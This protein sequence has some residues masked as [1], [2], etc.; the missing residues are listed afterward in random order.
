V[1]QIVSFGEWMETRRKRL[2]LTRKAL[3]VLAGCSTVTVQKI[4]RDERRPSVQLAQLLAQ[5][6]QIPENEQDDFIRRA[7]GE[8]VPD[9]PPPMTMTVTEDTGARFV[10]GELLAEGAHGQVYRG[11]DLV[12]GQPVVIKR[13]KP[14]LQ[15]QPEVVARFLR[16]SEALR[17]LNHPNI[18]KMLAAFAA[19]G[20]HTIVMEFVPGGSLR[21]LLDQNGKLSEAL[22]VDIAL[23]LADALSRAHHLDIL[24]RDLKPDNVLLAADG[25]PRLTDFGVARLVQEPAQLTTTGV[26]IGSPAYLSPEALRCEAVDSRADIWSFGV[27]LYEMLAGRRPFAGEQV[28]MIL[29]QILHDAPPPIEQ[30][31]PD[32]SP[33]LAVLIAQM[34]QKTA[35][36]RPSSMR[37]VAAAL[38][39]IGQG[40]GNGS[41]AVLIPSAPPI[42]TTPAITVSHN[43]PGQPTP[44]LGR[45]TELT[46]L[47]DLLTQP[48]SRLVTIVGPGGMGK[49]R[50]AMTLAESLLTTG[51]FTN[52]IFFVPLAPLNDPE[53]MVLALVEAL[54]FPL[55]SE[56]Q[57]RRTTQEQVLDYLCEKRLLLILDNFEHL[58]GDLALV[59]DI[60]QKTANVQIV[61]TSRERLQL[62]EEQVYPIEGLAFPEEGVEEVAGYTAVQLFLQTAQRI[63]PDFALQADDLPHLIRICQLVGG[64]PLGVELAAGWVDMLPLSEI[65]N[66]IQRSSDFLETELRNVPERHRSI[67][68]VFEASWQRLTA[69]EQ[70]VFPQLSVFRGGFTRRAGQAV[71]GASLRL[72]GRLGNKSLLQY[73]RQRDRYQVHELLRQFGA[74]LLA[75]QASEVSTISERHATYYCQA[76]HD[77]WPRLQGRDHKTA[78]ADIK[79]DAQNVQAA[80]A[81]AVAQKRG[82]LL[83]KAQHSLGYFYEWQGRY[84]AGEQAFRQASE[85][86]PADAAKLIWHGRFLHILGETETAVTKLQQA[87]TLL[88]QKELTSTDTQP[89][90]ARALQ[91][92]GSIRLHQGQIEAAQAHLQASLTLYQAVDDELSIAHVLMDL[93]Y[94]AHELSDYVV[95]NNYFEQGLLIYRRLGYERGIAKALEQLSLI[96][97]YQGNI[98][99]SEQLA[100]ESLAIY[101]ELGELPDLARGLSNLGIAIHFTGRFADGETL[102]QKGLAILSDIGD[103][104]WLIETR[105]RLGAAQHHLGNLA[106]ARHSFK[107][108]L[109]MAQAIGLSQGIGFALHMLGEVA[110]AE[111]NYE[112]AEQHLQECI[113]LFQQRHKPSYIGRAYSVLGICYLEAGDYEQA[114]RYLLE[115]LKIGVEI[116]DGMS[117][118]N[119]LMAL[120]RMLVERGETER[121]VEL[122]GLCLKNYPFY[123]ASQGMHAKLREPLTAVVANLPSDIAGAALIRGEEMDFWQTAESLLLEETQR[124]Q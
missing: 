42:P 71:T 9:M 115:A 30:F 98:E 54:R 40:R 45:A 51:Q 85:M 52:G 69:D 26:F 122:H 74:E 110:I 35:A 23:E 22:S 93:G 21:Q 44:F 28:A 34:L 14:H 2:G 6:L 1:T 75:K 82:D 95:A 56:G 100:I 24:H 72:L 15:E 121:A 53:Q 13:L 117:T 58:V 108:A 11:E 3:A 89:Q 63:Q 62:Q 120:A 5:H 46:A 76:L 114:Q 107:S 38:E 73:D 104:E 67:R 101:E 83:A 70:T 79:S 84:A 92:L 48:H 16:E 81:W 61:V 65:A 19:N 4:E 99:A 41:T 94:A 116:P 36:D 103:K 57:Q 88:E 7:R 119:V 39:A 59:T 112:E 18:V 27:L 33:D 43:L 29:A 97:R 32:I 66:E 20:R 123:R 8:F 87:L 37:Q 96:A 49:T 86:L 111:E 113:A 90:K 47:S 68:V 80:W 64:M 102:L 91:Y 25:S 17:Q 118:S 124:G 12:T 77:H 78:L 106:E 105:I 109:D 55:D 60:L 31:C 50:L 10:V